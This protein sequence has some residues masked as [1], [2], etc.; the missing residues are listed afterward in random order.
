MWEIRSSRFGYK[1]AENP[2]Y[3]SWRHL[4]ISCNWNLHGIFLYQW[5]TGAARF[6]LFSG[7]HGWFRVQS[8]VNS[9]IREWK[10]QYMHT[11][12]S[13]D[14]ECWQGEG[15]SCCGCTFPA[16]CDRILLIDVAFFGS[17][18]SSSHVRF[19]ISFRCWTKIPSCA[20]LCQNENHQ[21][22]CSDP[23][24]ERESLSAAH[25]ARFSTFVQKRNKRNPAL[26]KT[27]IMEIER[28]EQIGET[29]MS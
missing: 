5:A 23:S 29:T 15:D 26:P 9:T 8:L 14:A 7:T 10:Y 2:G 21:F 3:P 4:R 24:S 17:Q 6:W 19:F 28:Y 1:R 25:F 13:R 12:A 22:C 18:G 27:R 16:R 11:S 20:E